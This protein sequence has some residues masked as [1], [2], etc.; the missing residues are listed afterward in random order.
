M[1]YR[2]VDREQDILYILHLFTYNTKYIYTN[3]IYLHIILNIYELYIQNVYT[4]LSS[5]SLAFWLIA[6]YHA[7][8]SM[9]NY[10]GKINEIVK[11]DT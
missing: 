2:I 7:C 3:N 10:L 9:D 11:N 5:V 8:H 4:V 1:R 6:V